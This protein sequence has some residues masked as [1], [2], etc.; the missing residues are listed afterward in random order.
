MNS[1]KKNFIIS[2][3]IVVVFVLLITL[4]SN[5]FLTTQMGLK[6]NPGV[7]TIAV[8]ILGLFVF[9]LLSKPLLE[10]LFKSDVN[11]QKALKETLHELNIPVSTIKL[12]AKMLE[13]NIHDDKSL[14]RL[15]RI[16][17]ASNNLL[18]LYEQMEYSIKKEI[19]KVDFQWELL[20]S[21]IQESLA[22][23]EDIKGDIDI[24]VEVD[25]LKVYTDKKGFIKV[26]DNLISNAIK[27][28]TH[29]GHIH[30]VLKEHFLSIHNSGH[31]IDAQNLIQVF[32]KY[33]QENSSTEGFGLGLNI[34]KEFCDK[35]AIAIKIIP[36]SEG[37]TIQLNFKN[38]TT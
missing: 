35:H 8:L 7:I 11:L 2:Q 21:L 10:P 16:E 15:N 17:Q 20:E 4:G 25:E 9:F 37:T 5:Y 28:N 13:K 36:C 22:K 18:E 26:L 31:S 6:D 14:K 24:T 27:Y 1:K 19:D 38:I 12:N 34:V 23:F 32:D 33:Y 29:N 30:I 3:A